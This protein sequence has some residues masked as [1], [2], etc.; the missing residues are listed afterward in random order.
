M[1]SLQQK[2]CLVDI[3]PANISTAINNV[4]SYNNKQNEQFN[5]KH[6][7]NMTLKN[8][9]SLDVLMDTYSLNPNLF[10]NSVDSDKTEIVQNQTEAIVD[11]GQIQLDE[12]GQIQLYDHLSQPEAIVDDDDQIQFEIFDNDLSQNTFLSQTTEDEPK[13]P[14]LRRS[15]KI[16]RSPKYIEDFHR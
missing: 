10:S 15:T 8:T 2:S 16:R 9:I 12:S 7:A 14:I 6:G 13:D 3:L 5:K 11:N 4:D 1:R